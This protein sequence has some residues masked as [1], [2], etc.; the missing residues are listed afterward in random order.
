MEHVRDG[1]THTAFDGTVE[2]CV[3]DAG[4]ENSFRPENRQTQRPTQ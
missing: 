3:D 4:E 2:L 1:D